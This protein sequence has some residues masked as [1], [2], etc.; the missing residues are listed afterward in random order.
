MVAGLAVAC[1][2]LRTAAWRRG[3]MLRPHQTGAVDVLLLDCG[4]VSRVGLASIRRLGPQFCRLAA[5]AVAA[6]LVGGAPPQASRVPCL[7]AWFWDL[8][9]PQLG[10]DFRT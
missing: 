10:P 7:G 8:Q 6:R 4:G 2:H 3:R 5:Q 9:C 1:L